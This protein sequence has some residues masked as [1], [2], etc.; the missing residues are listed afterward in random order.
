MSWSEE[1]LGD[2]IRLHYGKA[3][4][5]PDRV[6]GG[7]FPV[8]GASGRVGSHNQGTFLGPSLI[9]GRKGSVGEITDAE[10]SGWVIDTAFYAEVLD[11]R[12]LDL[13]YLYHALVRARLGTKAITT[14][15]PGLNRDDAY[16]TPIPLPPLS[17]QK[18]IAAILDKADEVRRKRTETIRLSEELLKSAFLE[19]FGDPVTNPKGWPVSE[20]DEFISSERPITYGILKPGPDLADGVPYVRVVDIQDGVVVVER[21]RRTSKG[22]DH[23]FR[24]SRLRPGDLLMSIRG[25]VG[26]L[27]VVPPELDGAN[28]TQDTARIAPVGVDALY[29]MYLIQS[30]GIQFWMTRHVRGVAVRGINIGDVRRIPVTLPPASKQ[31]AF[32]ELVRRALHQKS[33]S[34]HSLAVEEELAQ[35]LTQRAFRGEL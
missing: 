10:S 34:T 31:S 30:P 4:K 18:R 21:V 22:I 2:L 20:L 7:E 13:R 6:E 16:Q 27:A 3:L 8:F 24:R 9:V 32:S 33:L 26:R 11:A 28:I 17:E 23:E 14:S 19:M 1:H 12:R 25:H 15:I 35:G 5:Q 29:L